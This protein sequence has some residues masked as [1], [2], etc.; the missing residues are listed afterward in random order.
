MRRNDF[1]VRLVSNC[2]PLSALV[3]AAVA[4]LLELPKSTLGRCTFGDTIVSADAPVRA[5][6]EHLDGDPHTPTIGKLLRFAVEGKTS[7][8]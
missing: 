4:K 3:V 6:S 7:E 8:R 2:N 5:L 1:E